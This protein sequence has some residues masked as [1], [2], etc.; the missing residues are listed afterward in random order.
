MSAKNRGCVLIDRF[1]IKEKFLLRTGWYGFLLVGT[2]AIYLKDPLWAWIYAAFGILGFALL[3]LPGMC[4]HCP[5]PYE[6]STCLFFPPALL[7]RFYAY[8]G[9]TMST[10]G[11]IAALST[12]AGLVILPNYWLIHDIRLA[13]LFWLLALPSLVVFPL[14]YCARCRHHGCPL[15]KAKR[16]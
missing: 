9:P 7:R 13:V 3:V 11:K 14:H 16:A 8:R 15:N 4:A 6:Y 10:A 1:S 12:L 2:Y 5:Y